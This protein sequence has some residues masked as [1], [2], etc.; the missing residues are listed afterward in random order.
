VLATDFPP[1]CIEELFENPAGLRPHPTPAGVFLKC[2]LAFSGSE[3]AVRQ[4]SAQHSGNNNKGLAIQ[5]K[6]RFEGIHSF[7]DRHGTQ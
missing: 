6:Q 3:T 7:F 4:I 1:N 2:R 5:G